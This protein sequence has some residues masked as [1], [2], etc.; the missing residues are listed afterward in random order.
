MHHTPTWNTSTASF[1]AT[2]APLEYENIKIRPCPRPP[3]KADVLKELQDLLVLK[4]LQSHDSRYRIMAM[5]SPDHRFFN[6]NYM[7][8]PHEN[9]KKK[10]TPRS[11]AP[12][13]KTFTVSRYK[14]SATLSPDHRFF[15]KNYM[16]PPAKTQKRKK[17]PDLS[18]LA[19]KRLQSHDIRFLL[20]R[21]MLSPDHRFFYKNYMPPSPKT[22]KRKETPIIFRSFK[23]SVKTNEEV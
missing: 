11:F 6:K 18:L 8:P 4:C 15:N 7:P 2:V 22:Q 14:I 10:E 17:L 21:A 13:S 9:A 3:P 1:K 5:L 12:R 20:I 23:S 19:V 16:P